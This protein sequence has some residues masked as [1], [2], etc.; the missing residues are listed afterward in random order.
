MTFSLSVFNN[1]I[2]HYIYLNQTVDAGGNPVV[3][4][5]SNKTFQYQQAGARLYG[6]EVS[7]TFH[8]VAW[9][10]FRFDNMF[11]LTYGINKKEN[12]KSKGIN[13]EY[14]PLIPPAQWVSGISQEINTSSVLFSSVT[15]KAEVEYNA[16]QNR[17]L[18]LYQ[19]ETATPSYTLINLSAGAT[20]RYYKNNQLQLQFQVNNLMDIAYQNNLSRLKYAEY[21][22]ASPNG[23]SGIYNSGRNICIKI[24]VPF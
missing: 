10:G 8:P 13:G 19:T 9:R 17:W 6:A 14:L 24:I 5:Q 20:I 23:Y 21:Y 3:D 12:Y 18:A 16:T 1:N 22:T 7:L 4:A 11:A 2:Q 15:A